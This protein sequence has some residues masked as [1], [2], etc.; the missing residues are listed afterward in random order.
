MLFLSS[1]HLSPRM[2]SPLKVLTRTVL[3]LSPYFNLFVVK[4]AVFHLSSV[5]VAPSRSGLEWGVS[6]LIWGCSVRRPVLTLA[7]LP[8][9][10]RSFTQSFQVSHGTVPQCTPPPSWYH[11][12]AHA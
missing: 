7:V 11:P 3:P 6:I 1:S 10:I 12:I 8:E 2:L 5:F 4:T 9:V